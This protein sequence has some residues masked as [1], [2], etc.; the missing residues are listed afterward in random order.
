MDIQALKRISFIS[1]VGLI[2]GI[3]LGISIKY[4]VTSEAIT[5]ATEICKP[6]SYTRV[7]VGISGKIYEVTCDNNKTFILK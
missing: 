6:G 3:L 4:P 2:L 1:G 7:K 5:T